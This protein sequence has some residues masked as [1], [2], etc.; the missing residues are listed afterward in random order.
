MERV[1]SGSIGL[2]CYWRT[3]TVSIRRYDGDWASTDRGCRVDLG[4]T[5]QVERKRVSV[6]K[7]RVHTSL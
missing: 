6:R 5:D 2:G 4:Y 1:L 7:Y 3:G